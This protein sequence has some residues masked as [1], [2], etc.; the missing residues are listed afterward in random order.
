MLSYVE[1]ARSVQ[2]SRLDVRRLWA[3]PEIPPFRQKGGVPLAKLTA[4]E[5]TAS[6]TNKFNKSVTFSDTSQVMED[7]EVAN[8]AISGRIS[9]GSAPT[10]PEPPPAVQS[11]RE[12]R[13]RSPD[14]HP[15]PLPHLY[16]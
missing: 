13:S 16:S 1:P 6:Q 12:A 7:E 2:P 3:V 15:H 9:R 10:Y 14:G 8:E 4:L 11:P 5:S